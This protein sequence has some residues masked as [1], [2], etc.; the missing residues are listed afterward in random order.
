MQK[1]LELDATLGLSAQPRSIPSKWFYDEKGSQLFD[2]ITR[3]DEYYLTRAEKQILQ[4]HAADIVRLTGADTIV[5]LGS[6]T[7]EK[8]AIILDAFSH[9][10]RLERF[11]PLD[12]DEVTLTAAATSIMSRYEGVS[13]TAVVGDFERNLG[14]LPVEG[15]RMI[16]FIGSTI[17]NLD[18]TQRKQFLAALTSNMRSGDSFLLGTDLVKDPA[19]L[20]AAYNDSKGITAMFNRNILEV[21]NARLAG[22]FVPRCFEHVAFYDEANEW[23]EMR[24]RSVGRQRVTLHKVDLVFDVEEGEEI[25][26]EI[27]TKF[28]REGVEDELGSVGS[29]QQAW[30]TD[31][32]GSFALS[33]WTKP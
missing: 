4:A 32:A 3:L 11:I 33:L 28:R 20:D 8:S 5:E 1:A 10:G 19:V 31:D 25:R 23:I 26:T 9:A 29:K 22:D 27:S 24:L 14:D 13:V 16:A 12:V 18:P 6:G 7:S 17:G 2:E 21:I 15:R 30:W